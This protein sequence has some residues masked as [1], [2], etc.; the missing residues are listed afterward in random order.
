MTPH[1]AFVWA[2]GASLLAEA[3]RAYVSI[4]KTGRTPKCWKIWFF[5]P[6]VL[7]IAA[8]A[9]FL[10]IAMDSPTRMNAMFVGFTCPFFVHRILA[11]QHLG[12][13]RSSSHPRV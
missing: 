5:L 11:E 13:G 7:A 12:R 2:A 1:D 9:G 8:G 3:V 6:L 4:R 10:A